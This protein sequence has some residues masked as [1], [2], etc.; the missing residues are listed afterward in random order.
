[1]ARFRQIGQSHLRRRAE[2]RAVAA[3]GRRH[4]A[5]LKSGLSPI[6]ILRTVLFGL[7]IAPTSFAWRA[8]DPVIIPRE[9]QSPGA[10]RA[11]TV[12]VANGGELAILF[13][14]LRADEKAAGNSEMPLLAVLRDGSH[15]VR[16]TSLVIAGIVT[17][18]VMVL[19]GAV[20]LRC[21]IGFGTGMLC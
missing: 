14:K 19:V 1:M 9:T 17:V 10:L 11:E 20:L 8:P 6:R 4:Y 2:G 13:E 16:V 5:G 7:I 3:D 18:T 15:A 21:W 12:K